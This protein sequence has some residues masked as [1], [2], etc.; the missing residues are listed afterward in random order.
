M[1]SSHNHNSYALVYIQNG[2]LVFNNLFEVLE[3]F[4]GYDRLACT[5]MSL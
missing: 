1:I 5:P 3:T 4:Y 2:L